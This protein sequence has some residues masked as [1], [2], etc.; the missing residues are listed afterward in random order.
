MASENGEYGSS[1]DLVLH[2]LEENDAA[3]QELKKELKNISTQLEVS[4]PDRVIAVSDQGGED[5]NRYLLLE[6]DNEKVKHSFFKKALYHILQDPP[7]ER[8][9]FVEHIEDNESNSHQLLFFIEE[10][11]EDD[12]LPTG[13][14]DEEELVN[15][16]HVA[17]EAG[18]K[19]V[20]EAEPELFTVD[21]SDDDGEPLWVAELNFKGDKA[22]EQLQEILLHLHMD[23]RED[24]P[25]FDF[26]V[27]E[28]GEELRLIWLGFAA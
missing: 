22:K 8:K 14:T 7:E 2:P 6:F 18:G 17:L 5:S 25:L 26:H 9:I 16:V 1:D 19:V 3:A 4:M 20:N 10:E 21:I 24:A 12:D 15:D 13:Y 11:R 27:L 28:E 23:D